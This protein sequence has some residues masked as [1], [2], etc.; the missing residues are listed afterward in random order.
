MADEEVKVEDQVTEQVA[1]E[2]KEPELPLAA[3][4]KEEPEKVEAAEVKEEEKKEE[5]KQDWRDKELKAKY[6]RQKELERELLEAKNELEAQKVLLS[7]FNQGKTEEA[8]NPDAEIDR[9]VQE[10]LAQQ[11]YLEKCNAADAKGKEIYKENWSQAVDNLQLLGG[12]DN[13]TMGGILAT[14]DPAKVL[15]E[16][17]KDPDKF[18]QIMALPF[19]RR[20]IE[21]GKIAMAPAAKP[22]S[23]APAPV[24]PVGGR[25]LPPKTVLRDEMPDEEWY[26]VRR[27][28][29]AEK[30]KAEARR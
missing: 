23:S 26:A 5:P 29:R 19:E 14:D 3:E 28:Q 17:G 16:L 7:K 10:R 6:R 12:F 1:E 18:H 13:Q 8:P 27:A 25:A 21:M 11:Q 2:N 24:N 30:R 15:F 22:I 20:I 9:R 4:A